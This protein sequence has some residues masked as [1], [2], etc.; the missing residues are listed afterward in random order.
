VPAR[1]LEDENLELDIPAVAF[2][3]DWSHWRVHPRRAHP[4]TRGKF[5][6]AWIDLIR[7]RPSHCTKTQKS[8]CYLGTWFGYVWLSQIFKHFRICFCTGLCIWRRGVAN[9]LVYPNGWNGEVQ[10]RINFV[11]GVSVHD[12][13]WKLNLKNSVA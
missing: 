11:V 5:G 3:G 1:Q 13:V 6:S 7:T 9:Q 4:G 8:C 10:G 2:A 12:W